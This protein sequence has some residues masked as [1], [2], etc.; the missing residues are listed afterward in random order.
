[1]KKGVFGSRLFRSKHEGGCRG[2][3]KMAAATSTTEAV[4]VWVNAK[5][6]V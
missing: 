2:G 4:S 6:F 5:L 1:M 3:W